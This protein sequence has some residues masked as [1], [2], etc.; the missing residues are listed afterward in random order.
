VSGSTPTTDPNAASPV[1]I[2]F[3]AAEFNGVD[4]YAEVTDPADGALDVGLQDFMLSYWIETTDAN[5]PAVYKAEGGIGTSIRYTSFVS[6]AGQAVGQVAQGGNICG[7][8]NDLTPVNDGE[9]HFVACVFDKSDRATV[10]VDGVPDN[11]QD[12][13]CS[14]IGDL[15]N[16]NDF[17]LARFGAFF[18]DGQLLDVRLY[19]FGVDGLPA[20]IG[21]AI[22]DLFEGGPGFMP[23]S[24]EDED[25]SGQFIHGNLSSFADTSVNANDL[26]AFGAPTFGPMVIE[27]DEGT[28]TEINLAYTAADFNGSDQYAEVSDPADGALDVGSQDFMLSYW[29]E[30]TDNDFPIVYKAEGG[31]GPVIHYSSYVS[32]A[33]QAVGHAGQDGNE[34]GPLNALTLVNDGSPHHVVVTFDKSDVATVYV[35]SVPD[36]SQVDDCSDIGSLDSDN[37]FRL[38]RF[39]TFFYDGKL[40]DV[41]LYRFG[42]NGLPSNIADAIVDLFK[43]GP[44]FM[45]ERLADEDLSGHFIP[46][47]LST[48]S[49][50]SGNGNDLTPFGDPLFVPLVIDIED[51]Y[52]R[53][54]LFDRP[55]AGTW[56]YSIFAVY[57]EYDTG[58]DERFS[59]EGSITVTI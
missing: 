7:P 23:T 38:A 50:Q 54:T 15:D 41:R 3:T 47:N 20:D 57:D 27:I 9:P 32:A 25:L 39:D 30:T 37:D 35:D 34:C 31:V 33:G 52:A 28:A 55:G 24:L 36:L 49:D 44:G 29:L 13:D 8:L 11:A 16:D 40:C 53:A 58:T 22:E 2:S 42:V 12:D 46:G 45:P 14:V 5:F 4:Q 10:Y 51:G 1:D 6:A 21:D 18:F 48:F 19:R 17:R 56:S 59:S 26:T 43:G